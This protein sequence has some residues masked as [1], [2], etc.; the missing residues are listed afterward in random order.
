MPR[1]SLEFSLENLFC[2]G[3][4][5]A[6]NNEW[7]ERRKV[8]FSYSSLFL[9]LS[10]DRPNRVNVSSMP[11]D[12]KCL[13]RRERNSI[14]LIFHSR[15][16]LARCH[17]GGFSARLARERKS[18]SNSISRGNSA[19]FYLTPN[20]LR[21]AAF[22]RR[23]FKLI[24]SSATRVLI[25]R[26]VHKSSGCC[27]NKKSPLIRT[28]F[29]FR[30]QRGRA[31]RLSPLSLFLLLLTVASSRIAPR[32]QSNLSNLLRAHISNPS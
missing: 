31:L 7:H 17:R 23:S 24:A 2:D 22:K 28:R 10:L 1:F 6:L 13:A 16:L 26:Q 4:R 27:V 20:C 25:S 18:G 3:S 11:G 9:F 15:K 21:R 29:P 14:A 5:R 30:R 19:P 32:F 12:E 8:L